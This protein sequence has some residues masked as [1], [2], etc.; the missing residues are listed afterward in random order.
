M[1]KISARLRQWLKRHFPRIFGSV[2][3][4][5]VTYTC[6]NPDGSIAWEKKHHLNGDTTVGLNDVLN[7]YFDSGTQKTSW[8]AGLINNSGFTALAASDTMSSHA[9]WSESTDYSEG[10]RPAWNPGAAS[11]GVMTGPA[12]SFSI[13]GTVTIKGSFLVSNST[14]GG[15]TGILMA[16]DAFDSNQSMTNGQTLNVT[17][18]KTF[19][20]A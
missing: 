2:L 9:G 4:G 20:A 7:V 8:F 16:T 3:V 5:V 1:L 6:V 18:T 17:W 13:N 14:K 11:G 19:T 12:I 10:T 15:T